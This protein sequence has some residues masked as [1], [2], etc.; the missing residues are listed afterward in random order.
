MLIHDGILIEAES[1]GQ[2]ELAKEIMRSTGR[3]TCDGLEIGVDVDQTLAG[4]ARYCDKRPMAKKMWET[5]M[6]T[7]KAVKAIPQDKR[8]A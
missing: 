5:I 4:G 8:A 7:L 3:D 6:S 1:P 2:V